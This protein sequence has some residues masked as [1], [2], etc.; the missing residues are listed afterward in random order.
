[1]S[2]TRKEGAASL[3]LAAL[4]DAKIRVNQVHLAYLHGAPALPR[5]A[6]LASGAAYAATEGVGETAV[7]TVRALHEELLRYQAFCTKSSCAIR[8]FTVRAL[9]HQAAN[10]I[11][12]ASL[13]GSSGCGFPRLAE[14]PTWPGAARE[15]R[16]D[17]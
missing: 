5:Q 11:A 2:A 17:G 7:D 1:M 4:C 16:L 14:K 8:L 13:G 12:A 9:R 15:A 10:R 6:G 3:L